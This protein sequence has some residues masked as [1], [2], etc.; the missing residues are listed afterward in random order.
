VQ[1]GERK[2]SPKLGADSGAYGDSFQKLS[3]RIEC[4]RCGP[5]Q[6]MIPAS[7]S[8]YVTRFSSTITAELIEVL[9]GVETL[10][11]KERKTR[12][13]AAF[14]KLLVPLV[15]KCFELLQ[16][17]LTDRQ[18]DKQINAPKTLLSHNRGS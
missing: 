15:L 6:P 1:N 9:F 17:E 2:P 13:D 8:L 10:G 11:P 18:T 3:G 16:N 4:M 5:L 14:A 12:F 7:V